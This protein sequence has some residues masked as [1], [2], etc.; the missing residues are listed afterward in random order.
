MKIIQNDHMEGE[1][2]KSRKTNENQK[3]EKHTRVQ[4]IELKSS[5]HTLIIGSPIS[6]FPKRRRECQPCI[7][8][9]AA[10]LSALPDPKA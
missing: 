9:A 5:P 10:S 8:R 6:P 7:A 1:K 4:F 3:L 2:G